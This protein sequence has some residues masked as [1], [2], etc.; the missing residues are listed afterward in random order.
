MIAR[1]N[2]FIA[3]FFL[4][5]IIFVITFIDCFFFFFNF[6]LLLL[7]LLVLDT[8]VYCS[9]TLYVVIY[10]HVHS[11]IHLNR[12]FKYT[13]THY[14]V[15]SALLLLLLLCLSPSLFLS[16]TDTLFFK[17]G[18]RCTTVI[19]KN[20]LSFT[21]RMVSQHTHSLYTLYCRRRKTEFF[22]GLG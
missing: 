9:N 12:P 2:L 11:L 3:V 13:R 14:G 7:L 22:F 5:K 6:Q 10:I 1:K 4:F 20:S 18:S 21:V 17:F 16:H 19:S 15:F 8:V